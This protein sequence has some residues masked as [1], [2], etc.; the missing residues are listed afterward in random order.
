MGGERRPE[1]RLKRWALLLFLLSLLAFVAEL[2]RTYTTVEVTSNSMAP[3]L[4]KGDRVL[5]N[6]RAYK[7]EPP[8]RGDIVCLLDPIRDGEMEVKRVVGLPGEWVAIVGGRVF[9]GREGLSWMALDEPYVKHNIVERPAMWF[10]PRGH[11]FVLGDN[12]GRSEDSRDWGPVPVR[13]IR[14]KVVYRYLPWERRGPVR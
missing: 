10:V 11:V 13:L 5:V 2:R 8:K 12:R 4:L 6:L 1:G 3:T 7:R 14:G 9:V